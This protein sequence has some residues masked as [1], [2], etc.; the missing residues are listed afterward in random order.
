M[1]QKIENWQYPVGEKSEKNSQDCSAFLELAEKE[2]KSEKDIND[3]I[4]ERIKFLNIEE[5][6]LAILKEDSASSAEEINKRQELVDNINDE[7]A[8]LGKK[9]SGIEKKAD[10]YV[11]SDKRAK[12]ILERFRPEIEH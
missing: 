4:N 5:A 6:K 12:E 2:K 11:K 9:K 1:A 3:R 10:L 8:K 7:I